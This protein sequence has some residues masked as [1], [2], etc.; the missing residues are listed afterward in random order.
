MTKC[1]EIMN[2]C[3]VTSLVVLFG[4]VLFEFAESGFFVSGYAKFLVMWSFVLNFLL[5]LE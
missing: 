5:E 1:Y 3:F 2:V 4:I